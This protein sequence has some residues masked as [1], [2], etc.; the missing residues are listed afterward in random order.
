GLKPCSRRLAT[1]IAAGARVSRSVPCTACPSRSRTVSTRGTC[2]PPPVDRHCGISSRPPM[3]RR[4]PS[5]AAPV[6]SCSARRI[7]TSSHTA[8]P[9]TTMLTVQ[10]ATPTILHGSAAAIAYHMAPLGIAEDTEGSIRVPA[11]LCGL[12]GFRPTT[13]RYSTA[14]CAPIT[15]LFDQLGPH[16][17]SVED[18][19]LFDGVV[20]GDV[21][22]PASASLKGVRLGLIRSFYWSGL[23]PEVER[24]TDAALKRLTDAG[25]ELV[26]A[27]LPELPHLIA[28]TT[29]PIQNHDVKPSLT[30]YLAEYHTGV[31]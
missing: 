12:A 26:E 30:R 25:I 7:C 5:C 29:D 20:T 28:L 9:E 21:Q 6:P 10:F 11:A 3:R 15:P 4:W 13:G 27:E 16:A 18:L 24:I 17:R 22:P 31:T 1:A 19:L 14:A 2:P 23:D 8:I